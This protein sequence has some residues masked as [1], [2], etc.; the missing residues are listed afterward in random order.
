MKNN[1]SLCT[2]VIKHMV[3]TYISNEAMIF[4]LINNRIPIFSIL[5]LLGKERT[6]QWKC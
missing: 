6:R 4:K 5:T 2:Y 1:N 3:I